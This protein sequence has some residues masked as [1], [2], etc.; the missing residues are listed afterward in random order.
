MRHP[1]NAQVPCCGDDWVGP[2][3]PPDPVTSVRAGW[4][5][6]DD[7]DGW[8]PGNPTD[9]CAL[10]PPMP[11]YGYSVA[12]GDGANPA[13]AGTP[14]GG[15]GG[16][17][18]NDGNTM[19]LSMCGTKIEHNDVVQH[20]SGIFFV[21]NDHSGNIVVDRSVISKNTGGSWYAIYPQISCHDDT[22]IAVTESTI[23]E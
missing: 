16:A 15:S 7:P 14:G 20:G 4:A 8:I 17:I 19:T 22:D 3:A 1:I 5:R 6:L 2:N 21:T 9:L 23:A 11:L 12:I 18:Y 13:A 10:D